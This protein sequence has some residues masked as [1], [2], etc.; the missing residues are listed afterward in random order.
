MP[1]PRRHFFPWDRPLLPQ[2]VA[3]LAQDWTGPAPLDLSRT[4]V[5]VPTRQ[6]GRR[7]REALAG[8]AAEREAA[9]FPP[10]VLTPEALVAAFEPA[11]RASRLEALLAWVEVL[12]S[13]ALDGFRDVFPLDPPTRSFGWALQLAEQFV[14]LQGTLAENRLRIGDVLERVGADFA[15]ADRW[16]QLAQLEQRHDE[17]LVRANRR[18]MHDLDVDAAA[19]PWFADVDA[20]VLL[21]TA[22]PLPSAIAV[23]ETYVAQKR[24]EVAI[25][26]DSAE[27]AAFDGWG[28][29]VPDLWRNR[30][31]EI[32][33]F[34]NRV[35]LCADPADEAARIAAAVATYRAVPAPS[36]VGDAS[37]DGW[38]AIGIADPEVLPLAETAVARTGLVTFNPEGELRRSGSLYHLLTALAECAEHPTFEALETLARCPDFLEFLRRRLGPTFSSAQFLSDLDQLRRRHM[39]ADLDAALAKGGARLKPPLAA[40]ADLCAQLLQRGFPQ[41]VSTVLANLFVGR[42]LNP[43]RESDAR[44]QDEATVWTATARE[45]GAAMAAFSGLAPHDWWELALRLFGESRRAAE[46]KAG[47]LELLGWLELLYE[48]APHLVVAGLNDGM[49][50]EAVSEDPFLPESLRARLGLKTNAGRFARDA[51]LL[52][53]IAASRTRSGQIDVLY[54]K[55]SAAGDPLRPSRL[56]LRCADTELPAR[57]AFLFRTPDPVGSHLPWSRAW[58]LTPRRL[59][60]PTEVAVT[61]LR[62]WLACPF[63]FYLKYVLRMEAIDG[64]KSEMDA[65]DFGTLCHAAFEAMGREA[66]LRDCTDASV[67]RE[68]LSTQLTRHAQERFGKNLSLPLLIQVE[69]AR[70]RLGKLADLQARERAAGWI[71]EAVEQPFAVEIGG[72]SVKGK[73]DRI[74]RNVDTGEVRVVDYKTS[75]TAVNPRQA[76]FRPVRA[77]DSAPEWARVTVEGKPRAWLDLQLPLYRHALAPTWG[78]AI[79]CGYFNLP[80]AV[81]QTALALWDDYTPELH[82]SAMR[83]AEGVCHA[84]R[85]GEF[86]PPNEDIRADSDEFATLFHHGVQS[87]VEWEGSD[88]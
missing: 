11:Q 28:R 26:A 62:R 39:P 32:A 24:V 65:F 12:R 31:L 27:S 85:A 87:S 29:P 5:L 1:S 16:A 68:F 41:N 78:H 84:I 86:W 44:L 52:Q 80:K 45:C 66:A 18:P 13:V 37:P 4:L 70:Q 20:I 67:L 75:D 54:A 73:I 59:P 79:A 33:D 35:R 63:R 6:S 22:D 50:P 77:D 15:E 36:S 7:L 82:E 30:V 23:L 72:L 43:A 57:I 60:P 58:R 42:V 3:F 61:S 8:L 46:K 56:L 71:I 25:F 38:L 2:A 48:D 76:H 74:D 51:Y 34:E 88:V 9:V 81:G 21:A 10:R 49:V 47:A 83:C 19:P 53:A 14:R 17:R 40:V 55:T 69:S 64:V